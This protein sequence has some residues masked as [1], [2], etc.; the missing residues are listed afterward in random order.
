MKDQAFW[1]KLLWMLTWSRRLPA[2]S[3]VPVVT[4]ALYLVPLAKCVVVE[5]R[6][7]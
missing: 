6:R 7:G 3:L 4:T 2:T 1:C 5:S